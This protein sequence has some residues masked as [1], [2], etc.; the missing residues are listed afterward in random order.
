MRS[1]RIFLG[2]A[3]GVAFGSLLFSHPVGAQSVPTDA[4]PGNCQVT[5]SE[6]AGMF[7]SG[8]VTLNG[9]AR[10]ADSTQFLLPDCGFFTWSHHMFLWLTSPAPRRYGGGSRI[11]FSPTFFTVSPPMGSGPPDQRRRN[12]IRNDPR[13][14]IRMFLRTTELGPHHLPVVM[15]RTGQL[16]EVAQ[17]L[18]RSNQR[19]MV[20]LQ[21]GKTVRLNDIRTSPTGGLQFLDQG[22]RALQVKK[23]TAPV[24][25]RVTVQLPDG[26]RPVL[27]PASAFQNAIQARKFVFRGIP[28]FLDFNGNV[29]DVE[30][31][32]ADNGVLISQGNSLIYYITVVNDVFAYHRTMQGGALIPF[33]TPLQ[34]PLTMANANSVAGFAASHGFTIVDPEALAIESK[35]SWVEASSVPN[36]G[37]YV[38][39][40]AVVPTFNKSDPNKWVPIGEKTVKLAMV[41]I[42]VVGS[43]NGHGEMVWGSFEHF[44]NAPNADY[45]YNSTSGL[46]HVA[47][48]TAGSWLFTPNGSSGPFNGHLGGTTTHPSWDSATGNIVGNPQPSPVTATAVLRT[49]PWGM[50]GNNAFTNTE[51]IGSNSS[52]LSQLIAP[53][54]R[55][56]YFQIGTTWTAGGKSP[57]G[58]NEAG[59]LFLANATVET[60]VQ[61][62]LTASPPTKGANCF[63]C[64]HT[65]TPGGTA[66][67]AVSHI[68]RQMNPL[69]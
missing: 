20:R 38:T 22:G 44:G 58:G 60:F 54:V 8:V 52:I 53:D 12:F 15:A 62:D 7:E 26:R 10:P 42:H 21:S 69:F 29:I 35:S 24:A 13:L 1:A 61:A 67:V 18:S 49:H 23:L 37:D 45:D 48:N 50:P 28:I 25:R 43:T 64:H 59:T 68:Y 56:N 11:M 34:F 6:V 27:V 40:D 63:S 30:T 57:N 41:G 14:P 31:G 5:P 16:V 32:Q 17:D 46:K 4:K 51:V 2:L 36:P 19:P 39:V 3:A 33:D 65:P 66:T 9:V 55:R 47:Q